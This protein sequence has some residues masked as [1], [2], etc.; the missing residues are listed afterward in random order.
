MK[1]FVRS[2]YFGPEIAGLFGG[3]LIAAFRLSAG[4]AHLVAI[5]LLVVVLV[6]GLNREK[7]ASA[8][9]SAS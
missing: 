8:G 1:S 7:R 2:H 9:E 3:V 4:V 6:V 5:A